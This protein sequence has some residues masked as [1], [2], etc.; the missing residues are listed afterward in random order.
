MFYLVQPYVAGSD[1]AR[2]STVVSTHDTVEA[3]C[4]E[5][6]AIADNVLRWQRPAWDDIT[7]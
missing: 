7:R 2:Q 5:L 4:A 3:A 1:R 6:D